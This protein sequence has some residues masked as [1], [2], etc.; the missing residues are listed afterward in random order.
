MRI[1]EAAAAIAGT[2]AAVISAPGSIELLLLTGAALLPEKR[3][4]II[5]RTVDPSRRIA[6]IIPAHNEEE[7]ITRSLD[8]LRAAQ[9]GWPQSDVI[10]IADN[11]T[12]GT[13][14]QAKQ[15]GAHVLIRTDPERRGKGYALDFAFRSLLGADYDAFLVVDADTVAEQNF[16]SECAHA[17]QNGASAVQC[18]YQAANPDASVRARLMKIALLAFN[19][20]RPKARERLGLSCGIYGNGFGLRSEVLRRVPYNASSVVEDLEYHINLIRAGLRVRFV[21]GTSVYGEMPIAGRGVSSQRERWEGGRFHMLFIQAPR[22]LADF[23]KGNFAAL[24]PLLDLLLLPLA[25][26]VCLLAVTLL[27]PVLMV[28][29]YGCLALALVAGHLLT[30]VTLG[31]NWRDLAALGAAPFYVLWKLTMLPRILISARTRTRWIRT[32][33]VAEQNR[34]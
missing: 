22:L 21:G 8:S 2:V 32:E 19:T 9:Q 17:L 24:E 28:K 15:A 13:A 3:K 6:V 27:S 29:M 4:S 5:A 34:S 18:R 14:E 20:L 33:R 25:L 30:A 1:L 12:D 11:C 31:G 7:G 23:K 16:I 26:H 10:V